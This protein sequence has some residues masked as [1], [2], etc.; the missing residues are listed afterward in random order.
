MTTIPSRF[1]GYSFS[2]LIVASLLHAAC[3]SNGSGGGSSTGG[4]AGDAGT[5]G[6]AG[7]SGS[8]AAPGTGGAVSTG[9]TGGEGGAV[10][11]AAGSGGTVDERADVIT[12]R[13][14]VEGGNHIWSM[15]IDGEDRV[16]LTTEN[17]NGNPRRSPD[18]TKI[19]FDRNIGGDIDL[20]V[21][22][23][24]GSNGVNLTAGVTENDA[25][26]TWSPDGAR[27]AF[28]SRRGPD[29]PG[30]RLGLYSML[31][32]GSDVQRILLDEDVSLQ[33][34]NWRG[35]NIAYSFAKSGKWDIWLKIAT[36]GDP[37]TNLT[38]TRYGDHTS[39][40]I[41]PD[42]TKILFVAPVSDEDADTEIFVMD[43]DGGNVEQLTD[44]D[45]DDDW[46]SFSPEGTGIVY[47]SMS[48]GTWDI[49]RMN[50]DGSEPTNLTPD[51][52]ASDEIYPNWGLGPAMD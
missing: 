21:M 35:D 13:S 14:N 30:G 17:S 4:A 28:V 20:W 3:G 48:A 8:G 6:N 22:D 39:P 40:V 41:S 32:D 1:F 12:F 33:H 49:W 27:M 9:G 10:G 47:G 23:A 24:D 45:A 7:D 25:Q 42:E 29:N 31:A 36:D 16:Q 34:P 2:A 26:A 11:G 46:P 5:G 19:V 52:D 51:L 50:L 44:N 15:G 43:A 37:G 18:G 38:E